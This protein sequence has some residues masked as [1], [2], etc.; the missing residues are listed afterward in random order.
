[1]DY[2]YFLQRRSCRNFQPSKISQEVLKDIVMQ[3]SKAPTCGNMQLYTVIAT[4]DP[5]KIQQLAK[6]H[7]NQPA[8]T[9]A[10]LIL[11]V[12]ADFNRFTRWC[13]I[14]EASPGYN[15]FHSFI[16]A[17]TDAVIFAQQIITVAENLG[18]GTCYLGT[19]TYNAKQIAEYLKIPNLVVPVASMAIGIPQE[20]GEKTSRLPVSAVLAYEEY[21]EFTD[22]QIKNLYKVHDEDP[23][24]K[25]FIEENHKSTLAQVF[26]EVRYPKELNEQVSESF[27]Q[28]LKDSGFIGWK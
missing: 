23:V 25:K 4:E 20:E 5:N 2:N 1:M 10:P 28:F 7:F 3:A 19:V 17:L 13:E 27:Y 9:T 11:T 14:S 22:E 26:A 16:T 21:P 24:N 12:C 6:Y 18:Y 15:N 8:A